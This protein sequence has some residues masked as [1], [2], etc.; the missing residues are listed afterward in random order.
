M[1]RCRRW[2]VWSHSGL[3]RSGGRRSAEAIGA[4]P[5]ERPQ[6]A[7]GRQ[8]VVIPA[9]T[10]SRD[11]VLRGEWLSPGALVCAAGAENRPQARELD[12]AVLQRAGSVCCDSLDDAKIESGD[13]IEPVEQGV[14]D[15]LEVHE[16]AGGR[17]RPGCRAASEAEACRLQVERDRGVGHRRRGRGGRAGA[18][19][20]RRPRGAIVQGVKASTDRGRFAER[21]LHGV[22]STGDPETIVIW[23]ERKDGGIWAVGRAVNPEWRTQKEPRPEDYVFEGYELGEALQEANETLEDDFTV[24]ESDGHAEH[25]KPFTRDERLSLSRP[26][27]SGASD[28]DLRL[29]AVSERRVRVPCT[30]A[31]PR[32][33]A[34]RPQARA[35]RHRGAEPAGGCRRAPGLEAELRC[36]GG[37]RRPLPAAEKRRRARSRRRPADRRARGGIARGGCGRAHRRSRP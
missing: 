3:R 6:E 23:I 35:A 29:H 16:L 34:V 20:R 1:R 22:D 25:V 36:G 30:R 21:V 31:R 37:R 18:G 4:E 13:L 32:S 7:A 27:S 17:V 19:G 15:W 28:A 24:S 12:N 33:G 10:A 5:A 11:P 8:D 14:L 2:S 26:G 9:I